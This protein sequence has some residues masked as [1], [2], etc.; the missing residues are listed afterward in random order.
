MALTGVHRGY[1]GS[2]WAMLGG[3]ASDRWEWNGRSRQVRIEGL[4]LSDRV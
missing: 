3:C 4:D 2:S 1:D